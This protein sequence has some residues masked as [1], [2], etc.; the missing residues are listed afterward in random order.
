[1]LTRITL[2]FVAL[3]ERLIQL[4]DSGTAQTDDIHAATALLQHRNVQHITQIVEWL[5]SYDINISKEESLH[6]VQATLHVSFTKKPH[7][8]N[9]DRFQPLGRSLLINNARTVVAKA[10]Y[11]ENKLSKREVSLLESSMLNT[12]ILAKLCDDIKLSPLVMC[13]KVALDIAKASTIRAIVAT[14][15][16][17][18]G[19][20]KC[21]KFVDKCIMP[22]LLKYVEESVRVPQDKVSQDIVPLPPKFVTVDG[23]PDYV[24]LLENYIRDEFKATVQ[25]RTLKGDMQAAR[26]LRLKRFK[27]TKKDRRKNIAIE[28]PDPS[29]WVGVFINRQ[30]MGNARGDSY[31]HAKH[32]AAKQVYDELRMAPYRREQLKNKL[33]NMSY[34]YSVSK[35]MGIE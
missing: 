29:L 33:T 9:N 20:E 14:I 19:P 5:K 8:A 10:L 4:R 26:R 2:T 6:Y 18:Q 1:V 7:L 24:T 17:Q 3:L 13:E 27:M 32:S 34:V 21:R 11:N 22:V 16:L 35:I 30:L 25:Y 31:T 15:Y 12:Q 23:V 28:N